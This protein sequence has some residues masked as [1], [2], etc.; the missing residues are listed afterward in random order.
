MLSG[1]GADCRG[2]GP[3]EHPRTSFLLGGVCAG[4][5]AAL[6][7]AMKHGRWLNRAEIEL[8]VLSRQGLDRRLDDAETLRN[9]T[10]AWQQ[11]NVASKTIDGQ[12]T[13]ADAQVKR[14]RLYP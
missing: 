12:F 1:G 14:K 8:R 4:R 3:F 10:Q 13:T 11:R 7:R 2:T 6:K 9:E 5:G